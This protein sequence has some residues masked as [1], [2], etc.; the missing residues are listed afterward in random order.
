MCAAHTP[1][2]PQSLPPFRR[3]KLK[4]NQQSILNGGSFFF[5]FF[6]SKL[7]PS[8]CSA[9][10]NTGVFCVCVRGYTTEIV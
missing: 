2:C 6:L 10:H 3:D 1:A 7:A 9:V 8:K 4:N 5:L